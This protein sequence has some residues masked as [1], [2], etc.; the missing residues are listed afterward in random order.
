[1]GNLKL[2]KIQL[3]R[4]KIALQKITT[5]MWV[6][7]V[8]KNSQ[9]QT[10]IRP[11]YAKYWF[12]EKLPQISQIHK[13]CHSFKYNWNFQDQLLLPYKFHSS[14]MTEIL[15]F[16]FASC[17]LLRLFGKCKAYHFLFILT[18]LFVYLYDSVFCSPFSMRWHPKTNPFIFSSKVWL[19]HHCAIFSR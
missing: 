16:N 9:I 13:N 18:F 2:I 8:Q 17:E 7:C 14:S 4:K 1:M 5:I 3:G 11:K 15:S 6:T 10:I 12:F 19:N